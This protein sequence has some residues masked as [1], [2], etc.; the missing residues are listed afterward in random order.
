MNEIITRLLDW[1]YEHDYGVSIDTKLTDKPFPY[2]I[3]VLSRN[4]YNV[5]H[6]FDLDRFPKNENLYPSTKWF[7]AGFD[8][9]LQSF[10]EFAENRFSE[11]EA[12]VNE[13]NDETR[14]TTD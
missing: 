5:R 6:T 9:E 10:L 12:E 13:E 8:Y 3:V 2:V 7:D 4:D 11:H 14:K 1:C